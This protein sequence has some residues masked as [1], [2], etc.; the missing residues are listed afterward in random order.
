MYIWLN[1]FKV[2]SYSLHTQQNNS[3]L[4]N[5]TST[6]SYK[7]VSSESPKRITIHF[8]VLSLVSYL[9]IYL[10]YILKLIPLSIIVINDRRYNSLS[11]RMIHYVTKLTIIIQICNLLDH[12]TMNNMII[13]KMN[14]Q[15]EVK[16]GS[17]L[18]HLASASVCQW[19][20][21]SV[22][23]IKIIKN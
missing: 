3:Q 14:K 5:K 12:P 20:S 19:V 6:L 8:S 4:T 16:L 23:N 9:K 15:G 18:L 13:T 7:I 17:E 21:L 22:K 11:V 10:F 2:S 1:P